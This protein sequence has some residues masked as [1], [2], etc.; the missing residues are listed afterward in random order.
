MHV[1]LT[2]STSTNPQA[3]APAEDSHHQ[4]PA[5]Q[6]W[7]FLKCCLRIPTKPR[8]RSV[9]PATIQMRVPA[10][11]PIIALNTLAPSAAM[12]D[13]PSPLCESF[14]WAVESQSCRSRLV[15]DC[16]AQL[17]SRAA[18]ATRTASKPGV[19][20]FSGSNRVGEKL[21]R[22][23]RLNGTPPA[24]QCDKPVDRCLDSG[25]AGSRADGGHPRTGWRR[26]TRFSP[27]C[28]LGWASE[29]GPV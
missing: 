18:C 29:A 4:T 16:F 21:A 2:P 14:P 25:D 3:V 6:E 24:P 19:S 17:P 11:H 1:E 8:H 26:A 28:P 22:R 13:R 15:L 5:T 23:L 12:P 7:V 10:A 27:S 20:R 9:T